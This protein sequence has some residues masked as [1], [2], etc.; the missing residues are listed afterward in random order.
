MGREQSACLDSD[1]LAGSAGRRAF[2]PVACTSG[3]AERSVAEGEPEDWI[4]A[5]AQAK[6]REA[7]K[8][9]FAAFAPRLK[10]FARRLGAE[11]SVAE[12]LA[13]DVMLTVW[14]RSGQFD[15]RKAAASTW[16]YTIARNR[17]IDMIR[18]DARPEYDPEDPTLTGR[19]EEPQADSQLAMRRQAEALHQAVAELPPEQADLMRLAYFDDKSHGVI[20]E[21]LGLPLGTVKSRIRLAMSKLRLTLKEDE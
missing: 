14:R 3:I 19:G 16:I 10:A 1:A 6:D 11:P 15:R 13:Q 20:A 12:D 8:R 17:R 9:L 18:R 2:H 7:F 5:I 4:E 21:E